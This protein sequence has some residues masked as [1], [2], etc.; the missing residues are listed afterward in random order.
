MADTLATV[1][2]KVRALLND[3]DVQEYQDSVLLPYVGMAQSRLDAFLRS[4]GIERYRL[5][6][7]VTVPA[8]V[9]ALTLTST[10]PLP[11]DFVQPV[12]LHERAAGSTLVSDWRG[13][14]QVREDLANTEQRELLGF[15]AWQGGAIRFAGATANREVQIDYL[16]VPPEVALPTD[17]LPMIDSAEAVALL[18]AALVCGAKGAEA[19][20]AGFERDYAR[21]RENL[22]AT[23]I[24][25]KQRRVL[26]R[27]VY[28]PSR[29][30]LP[31][32]T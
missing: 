21:E 30:R 9:K 13:M 17:A 8:G 4:K 6:A 14:V 10:P 28:H 27:E 24:R 16:T 20:K 18:T 31:H 25:Q 26:R 12:V 23:A 32:I 3:L 29:T 19:A 2:G 7:T 22:Y 5:E 15:W 1:T 11:A